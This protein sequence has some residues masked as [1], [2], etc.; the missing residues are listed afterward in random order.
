VQFFVW[1]GYAKSFNKTQ[2]GTEPMSTAK[3]SKDHGEL[4]SI[5][6]RELFTCEVVVLRVSL[7]RGNS[8]QSNP[9]AFEFLCSPLANEINGQVL[10]RDY[11]AGFGIFL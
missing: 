1:R 5:I 8:P 10:S 2:E 11:G 7:G 3:F 6:Q 4:F 9:N